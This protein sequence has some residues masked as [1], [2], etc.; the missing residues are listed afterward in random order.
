[1][2]HRTGLLEAIRIGKWTYYKRNEEVIEEICN[3]IVKE[4]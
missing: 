1:M 2:L 4:I 3:Y